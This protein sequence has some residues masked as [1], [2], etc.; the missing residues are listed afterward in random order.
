LQ[1]NSEGRARARSEQQHQ[2]EK[3]LDQEQSSA[4]HAGLEEC[5][6]D[7]HRPRLIIARASRTP[8][9]L[10]V[11][12]KTVQRSRAELGK[13]YP[14]LENV[15]VVEVEDESE[16]GDEEDMGDRR[17][18]EDK[19][20]DGDDDARGPELEVQHALEGGEE[21][22]LFETEVDI[23]PQ[24]HE[25]GDEQSPDKP[26]SEDDD[27]DDGDDDNDDDSAYGSFNIDLPEAACPSMSPSHLLL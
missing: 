15:V 21:S 19:D 22:S 7:R 26:S 3:E 20:G 13:M 10:T 5:R 11:R 14:F 1:T 12:K 6:E 25:R 16:D 4:L 27:D 2:S 17:A 23:Q 18:C 24:K 9:N 8:A